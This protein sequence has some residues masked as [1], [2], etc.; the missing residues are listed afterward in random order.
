MHV[1]AP[2]TTVGVMVD[3]TRLLRV[4]AV[5]AAPG[6]AKGRYVRYWMI[7]ARRTTWS[8]ALGHA[9]AVAK[10]LARTLVVLEPLRAGY[11]WACDRFHAVVMQGMADNAKRFAAR[12]VTYLSYVE[13]AP[14]EGSGLLETL[15]KHAC[16]VVTD[17]QPGFFLPRMVAAVAKR[18]PVRVVARTFPTAMAFRRELQR[19]LPTHLAQLPS[20]DPL[21]RLPAA[22][23]DGELPKLR[24]H[25]ATELSR[26][27]IDH[28]I[29]PVSYRGGPVAAAATLKAFIAAFF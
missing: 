2:R 4:T 26:I 20:A 29:A 18:L 7:A 6:A 19:Q 5:N 28:A 15:A 3:A 21:A 25:S 22:L 27:P 17:E 1:S 13:P 23:R 10:Q 24:W 12:G 8:L 14:G 16:C 11:P 9:V